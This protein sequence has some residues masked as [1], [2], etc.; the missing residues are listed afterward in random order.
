VS[1]TVS[2]QDDVVTGR[3]RRDSGRAQQES[4]QYCRRGQD[5]GP[6]PRESGTTH[7]H[8][9]SPPPP[10]VELFRPVGALTTDFGH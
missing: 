1:E 5:R 10:S 8:R 2:G 3:L 9:L 7:V 4:R 6:S